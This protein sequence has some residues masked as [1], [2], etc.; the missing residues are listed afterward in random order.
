M[1]N[2]T[3]KG[4]T[5]C[6][7]DMGLLK[8]AK[9]TTDIAGTQPQKTEPSENLQAKKLV[10]RL[11]ELAIGTEDKEGMAKEL[12]PLIRWH[13]DHLEMKK[14]QLDAATIDA[15]FQLHS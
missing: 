6:Y 9:S 7:K 5:M 1:T 8:D 13:Q 10:N 2:L 15:D 12:E 3:T 11:L 4:L 14:K